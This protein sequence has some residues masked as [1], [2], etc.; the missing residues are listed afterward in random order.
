MEKPK[1]SEF[2]QI[3][4][5]NECRKGYS[6]AIDVKGELKFYYH[7]AETRICIAFAGD[8]MVDM[9]TAALEHLRIPE[10]EV[11]DA[12]FCIW[13]S[14]SAGVPMINP[15]CQWSDFTDRGDI[16]GFDSKRIKTAFHWGELSVNVMDLETNVGIYWV[17]SASK[18][19]YWVQSSPLRSLFH[20]WLEKNKVQLLH[21]AA[22]GTA[23]GAVLITGKGGVGKSTTALKCL[24]QGMFYLSDDYVIVK[25]E[26]DPLI[27]SLYSTAKLNKEDLEKFP[28]FSDFIAPL[29]KDSQEKAVMFLYPG[30]KERIVSEMPLKAILMPFIT[31]NEGS[32][33]STVPYWTIQGAMSFTTLSQLPNVGRQT[34]DYICHLCNN[35]PSFKLL[36]GKDLSE[37]PLVVSGFLSKLNEK[38]GFNTEEQQTGESWPLI[39]VIVPVYN[40]EEF[41]KE[42]ISNILAQDYPALEIIIVNDGST[43][44]TESIIKSFQLDIRYLYQENAGPA[45]ARNRGIRDASGEFIAFLD[46][47]DLWPENNLKLLTREILQESGTE[48]VHGYGQL[49]KKN[50]QTQGWDYLGNPLESFP[51]YIGAGLY[52]KSVF[53]E[54]GLF[55]TFL[56]FGED[57]D[58]F[59]RASELKINLKKLEEVTLYVRRHGKNMTEG[60]SMV[61]LNV[62]RV[63][64]NAL[65]RIRK[66]NPENK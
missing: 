31:E 64:K 57:A 56:N 15:P 61:E 5:Y 11:V 28:F 48:V 7:I 36:T 43:D 23:N 42:A 29:R 52:R 21:A 22:V 62:L 20:W 24:E 2:E 14:E 55:D 10:P 41:I 66:Q 34:H 46:A 30:L 25:A 63:F 58:W 51:G 1:K 35:I 45:S 38:S 53:N 13:D 37:I 50:E 27:Y 12:T 44:Q 26:P 49:L 19:P 40:G 32:E 6:A 65:D 8:R 18:L 47:D 16:W 60:K 33:I 39:S 3:Q 17:Q 9:M 4:F 54:V 59:N